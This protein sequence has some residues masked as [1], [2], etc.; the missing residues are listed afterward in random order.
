MSKLYEHMKPQEFVRAL[1]GSS[2]AER[3]KDAA[4]ALE[5]RKRDAA[6]ELYEA[7][8]KA[9]ARIALLNDTLAQLASLGATV[10]ICGAEYD[11]AEARAALAKAE[12]KS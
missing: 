9:V 7:L 4:D 10:A 2:D 11:D 12:G 5:Q 1:L 6:P 8:R 3:A